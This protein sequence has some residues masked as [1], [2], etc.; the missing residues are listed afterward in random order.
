M[1][2]KL[3]EEIKIRL[4]NIISK[5]FAVLIGDANGSDK[6]VQKFFLEQRYRRVSVYCSGQE[7][8]NNL[9]AWETVH[10]NVPRKTKDREFYAFK[11][12]QMAADC[13]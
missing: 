7:C 2:S 12:T 9:G 8:R 13:D 3:N 5:N 1:I 4:K 6:A 10:V 11:D